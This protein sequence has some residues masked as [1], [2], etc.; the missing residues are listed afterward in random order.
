MKRCQMIVDVGR[1]Q[2]LSGAS[3]AAAGVAAATVAAPR[4]KAAPPSA[5]VNYPS[6]RLANV[7]ELKV[8]EP[9]RADCCKA[10]DVTI[11]ALFELNGTA[12]TAR[13]KLTTANIA[14]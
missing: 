6:N 12:K 8:N 13:T 11:R 14:P 1:R 4:A 5:R 7:S 3:M 2:F 10:D 9:L